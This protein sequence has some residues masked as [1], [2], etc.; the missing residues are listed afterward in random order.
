MFGGVWMFARGK[1]GI[2]VRKF[3]SEKETFQRRHDASG[4]QLLACSQL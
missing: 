1:L 3:I 2:A 4:E